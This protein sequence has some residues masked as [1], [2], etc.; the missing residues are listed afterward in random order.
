MGGQLMPSRTDVSKIELNFKNRKCLTYTVNRSKVTKVV[1]LSTPT[2]DQDHQLKDKYHIKGENYNLKCLQSKELTFVDCQIC[3][4]LCLHQKFPLA[5][6]CCFRNSY[7]FFSQINVITNH[8]S[9]PGL[10]RF[11]RHRGTKS[12]NKNLILVTLVTLK[13]TSAIKQFKFDKLLESGDIESN[14]GPKYHIVSVK[15]YNV[16]GLKNK[17]KLKRVLNT[18][19][20]EISQN[21]GSIIFLQETHLEE[22][23]RVTLDMMW[24]HSYV[25]SPGTNR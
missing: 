24:R 5:I 7:Q 4:S 18:C 12:L 23:D 1:F 21:N 11:F 10:S 6:H 13:L 14:P 15:S 17:L 19:H 16:R 8:K 20:K 25:S 9:I 2:S 3:C 22:N